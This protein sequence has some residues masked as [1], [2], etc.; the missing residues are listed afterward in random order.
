MVNFQLSS[1]SISKNEPL[2]LR[3]G[4]HPA[5]A[6]ASRLGIELHGV[7]ELETVFRLSTTLSATVVDGKLE[8]TLKGDIASRTLS[9][10]RLFEIA[11]IQIVDAEGSVAARIT[12]GTDFPRVFFRVKETPDEPLLTSEQATQGALE[13]ERAREEMYAK[14]LGDPQIPGSEEFRIVMFIERLLLTHPLRVPGIQMTLLI[15]SWQPVQKS[16][17]FGASDELEVINKVLR[18]WHW[19]SPQQTVDPYSWRESNSSNRPVVLMHVPRIFATSTSRALWLAHN[20][21]D[22]LLELLAFRRNALGVPFA[23]VIQQLDRTT[24]QYTDLRVYPE[25]EQYKGNLMGGFL[26]GEDQSVLMADYKAMRSEPFLSFVLYLHAEAQAEKDLDFAYFR[27]WNLLET[28]ASER[29]EPGTPVTDFNAKQVL[30]GDGK[31]FD[32]GGARGRVYELVKRGMQEHGQS[33][34]THQEARDLSLSLWGAVHVWYAFRNATAHHGGFNIDDANQQRQ[35]WYS[36]AVEAQGRGAQPS[37]YKKDPYFSY[38]KAI[39]TDVVRWL[40]ESDRDTNSTSTWVL[41]GGEN[42]TNSRE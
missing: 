10:G 28:I 39:T 32:T 18:D 38:L 15:E 14:P 37:G 4:E 20:R 7:E 33:E 29:V 13:V 9:A 40:L 2:I 19:T 34:E 27:Y 36:V 11:A 31:A 25:V 5:L 30:K 26:A 42:P 8:A 1:H 22:R 41:E 6:N 12:G 23:T 3:V 35:S 21:R 17:G 16:F 24:G